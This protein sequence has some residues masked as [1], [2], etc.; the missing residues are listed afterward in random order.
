[1]ES[2]ELTHQQS[3]VVVAQIGKEM[4]LHIQYCKGFGISLEEI[5]DTEEKEG[6]ETESTLIFK[7]PSNLSI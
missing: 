7:V 3:A 5:E 2:R 1:M 4:Q 6:K